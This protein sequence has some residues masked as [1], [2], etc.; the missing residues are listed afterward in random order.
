MK[1]NINAL[2]S[3][4]AELTVALTAKRNGKDVLNHSGN[5]IWI[6]QSLEAMLI[7]SESNS[8][9]FTTTI[10][11]EI[12][13]SDDIQISLWNRNGIPVKIQSISIEVIENI[14]N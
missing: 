4:D 7:N 13:A 2:T 10:P 11:K 5:K 14:W 6:G 1:I 3:R 8:A 12:N 9:Y